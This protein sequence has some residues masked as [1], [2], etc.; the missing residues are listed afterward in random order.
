MNTEK[1]TWQ[2]QVQQQQQQEMQQQQQQQQN[3]GG[4]GGPAIPEGYLS[5]AEVD[6]RIREAVDREVAGLKKNRDDLMAEKKALEGKANP[7]LALGVD[8]EE[9]EK[10]VEFV[11][12]QNFKKLIA[13]GDFDKLTEEVRTDAQK[14][15]EKEWRA[16]FDREAAEKQTVISERDTFMAELKKLRVTDRIRDAALKGGVD[17]KAIESAILHGDKLFDLDDKGQCV[18]VRDGVQVPG[19]SGPLTPEEWVTE[20]LL[21]EHPYLRARTE[22]PGG[23][24]SDDQRG[25]PGGAGK[26]EMTRA[27]FDKKSEAEKHRIM[28]EGKTRIV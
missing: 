5:Q 1:L 17:P 20:T 24:G 21:K 2:R 6:R 18:A 15:V 22:G 28:S 13:A 10:A 11:K 14:R 19:K 9:A 16:K 7:F 3:P 23:M 27:E 25:N 12:S 26:S 4:G 8:P